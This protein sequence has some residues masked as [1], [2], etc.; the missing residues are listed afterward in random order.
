M[1]KFLTLIAAGL[2]LLM[3]MPAAALT[4]DEGIAQLEAQNAAYVE[5]RDELLPL[6]SKEDEKLFKEYN[7]KIKQNDD[8]IV[9]LESGTV[10]EDKVDKVLENN[11]GSVSPT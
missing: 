8:V 2:A 11:P 9:R 1:R 5:L 7:R 6:E 4:I 3:A 10:K